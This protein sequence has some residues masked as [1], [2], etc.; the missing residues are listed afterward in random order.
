M[1]VTTGKGRAKVTVPVT[2]RAT[3]NHGPHLARARSDAQPW[4]V[5]T[6]ADVS[7]WVRSYDTRKTV[8]R[9]ESFSSCHVWI[10]VNIVARANQRAS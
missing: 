10:M 3:K 1:P 5:S 6:Q 7:P 8:I 9:R 2:A 4:V